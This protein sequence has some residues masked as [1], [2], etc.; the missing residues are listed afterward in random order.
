MSLR[1][2]SGLLLMA[3]VISKSAPWETTI[4]TQ[5]FTIHT[6]LFTVHTRWT[7]S[8]TPNRLLRMAEVSSKST[9]WGTIIHTPRTTL[10]GPQ[11]T[12]HGPQFTRHGPQF[13]RHKPQFT[14]PGSQL[15]H[16]GSLSHMLYTHITSHPLIHAQTIR[17]SMYKTYETKMQTGVVR[18]GT[19]VEL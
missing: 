13:T 15:T 6:P 12:R 2:P 7:T 1:V 14:H 9:P 17:L 19:R 16:H 11:L 10:H 3:D 8:Y 5:L 18:Q 4:H